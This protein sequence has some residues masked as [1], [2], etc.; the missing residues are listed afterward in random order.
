MACSDDRC[1]E[2]A[3]VSVAVVEGGSVGG[4]EDVGDVAAVEIDFLGVE[5]E[6][7]GAG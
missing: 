1:V 7:L 3:A 2:V 4:E 6:G 5:G